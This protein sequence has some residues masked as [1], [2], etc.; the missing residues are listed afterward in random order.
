MGPVAMHPPT[1]HVLLCCVLSLAGAQ[2]AHFPAAG[3]G[4]KP[5]RPAPTRQE[6]A[7]PPSRQV[8]QEVDYDDYEDIPVPRKVIPRNRGQTNTNSRAG[9]SAKTIPRKST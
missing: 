4:G 6:V 1:H 2:F 9:A 7:R 3:G 5:S 8:Q